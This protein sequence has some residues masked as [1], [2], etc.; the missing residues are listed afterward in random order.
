VET[1]GGRMKKIFIAIIIL[2]ASI[3]F[4]EEKRDVQKDNPEGYWK[5]KEMESSYILNGFKLRQDRLS[6]AKWHKREMTGKQMEKDSL[7]VEMKKRNDAFNKSDSLRFENEK[8]FVNEQVVKI[9]KVVKDNKDNV[10]KYKGKKKV[11][12]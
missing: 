6:K 2:I 10:K 3:A 7:W 12:L 1:I 8:K 11:I 5:C 4:A 9:T